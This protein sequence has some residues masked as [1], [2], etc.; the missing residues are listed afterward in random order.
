[1]NIDISTYDKTRILRVGQGYGPQ[2]LGGPDK[3]KPEDIVTILIHTTNN[4]ERITTFEDEADF[5]YKSKKVSAH[6][7]NG[8]KRNQIVQFLNPEWIAWHAGFV[9]NSIYDNFH[10]IGIENHYSVGVGDS[11]TQ[12]MHDNLTELVTWLL[13]KYPSIKYIETHRKAAPTRKV[14]PS[15]WNDVDFY[16]WANQMLR[17]R[18]ACTELKKY[19]VIVDKLNI[20]QAPRADRDNIAGFF[21]NGDTFISDYIKQDEAGQTHN[22]SNQWAHVKAGITQGQIVDNL[23]YVSVGYLEQVV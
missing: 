8:K 12:D 14:D 5:L 16:A 3:R 20:R 7:L 10:S 13:Q 4:T 17:N 6:Y 23:G 11:W 2:Y 15:G 22:G 1:M 19:K 9:V 18:G 21:V